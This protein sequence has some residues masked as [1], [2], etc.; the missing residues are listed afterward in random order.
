MS[1]IHYNNTERHRSSGCHCQCNLYVGKTHAAPAN[2]LACP[3]HS[4]LN[5]V[6]VQHASINWSVISPPP[7]SHR[8]SSH[9]RIASYTQLENT[10]LCATNTAVSVILVEKLE[11][12][13]AGNRSSWHVGRWQ[14]P[15]TDR[16]YWLTAMFYCCTVSPETGT[17]GVVRQCRDEMLK[18]DILN[19]SCI[20][21]INGFVTDGA[22]DT[23]YTRLTKLTRTDQQSGE[24]SATRKCHVHSATSLK[25]TFDKELLT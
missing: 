13:S 10:P 20:A 1:V 21:L 22:T 4:T 9:K 17:V 14:L 23:K 5:D 2:L 12:W 16:C 6:T 11:N 3:R 18:S 25:L 19:D 7:Y 24:D 15:V 8:T